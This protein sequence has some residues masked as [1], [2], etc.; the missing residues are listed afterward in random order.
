[1]W[2]RGM[3]GVPQDDGTYK[4]VRYEAKVYEEGSEYGIDG[5][6]I[7]KLRLTMGDKVVCNYDRGWDLLPTCQEAEIALETIKLDYK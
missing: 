4:A 3:I 6:R 5:G 7:S 2:K 1:M